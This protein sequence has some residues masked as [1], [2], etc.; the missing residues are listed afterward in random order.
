ML[1]STPKLNGDFEMLDWEEH[2][3]KPVII[4][5]IDEAEGIPVSHQHDWFKSWCND[6]GIAFKQVNGCYKGKFEVA[7]VMFADMEERLWK[8]WC[9][10][11]ESILFLTG[12]VPG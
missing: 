6:R 5:A 2:K 1:W 4:F 11:Q 7:Y 12:K 8:T 10:R 3:R 9:K